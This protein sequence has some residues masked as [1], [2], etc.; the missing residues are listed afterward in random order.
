VTKPVTIEKVDA[1]KLPAKAQKAAAIPS[2]TTD[3]QDCISYTIYQVALSDPTKVEDDTF[4]AGVTGG[5]V[6]AC[7]PQDKIGELLTAD[8]KKQT[9]TTDEQ[10][11]CVRSAITS[12]DATS[13]ATFVGALVADLTVVTQAVFK[14]IDG[15]C[16]T[17]LAG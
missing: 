12:A 13:L 16:G 6:V 3:Q 1:S 10:V 8:L 4:I 14:A 9:G 17:K 2:I 11:A 7:V 15:A 5:A